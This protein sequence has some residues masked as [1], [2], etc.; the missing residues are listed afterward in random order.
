M[1]TLRA[2]IARRAARQLRRPLVVAALVLSLAA[3]A[4]PTTQAADSPEVRLYDVKVSGVLRTKFALHDKLSDVIW[5][6]VASW[7]ATYEGVRLE[8]QT[9]TKLYPAEN[10]AEEDVFMSLDGRGKITGTI[11]YQNASGKLC[12]W[13]TDRPVPGMLRISGT[14]H[15]ESAPGPARYS[16]T[17]GSWQ[18]GNPPPVR[19]PG[20]T[21]HGDSRMAE[22]DRVTIGAGVGSGW[23][24]TRVGQ[25]ELEFRSPQHG[26]EMGFPLNRLRAGAG[27]VLV[28]EGRTKKPFGA[29]LSEG[30]V[31]YVFQPHGS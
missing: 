3:L 26:S 11:K 17:L 28:L 27:F 25:L 30:S 13:R 19:I 10:R 21:Y 5:S 15:D 6:E 8:L 23:I 18:S 12:G 29:F 9:L 16:L 7:T 24:D 31:R 1:T 22:F 14:P 4:T 20:C 2:P